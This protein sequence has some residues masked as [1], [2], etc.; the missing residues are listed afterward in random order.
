MAY[1]DIKRTI[2]SMLKN[3][4]NKSLP[5]DVIYNL[6]L[7]QGL[8]KSSVSNAKSQLIADGVIEETRDEEGNKIITLINEYK[9][10]FDN[11][12]SLMDEDTLLFEMVR[13][14]LTNY[15]KSKHLDEI[16]ITLML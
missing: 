3:S 11:E 12:S 4:L 13:D 8:P 10:Y 7:A 9:L 1:E 6:L 15:L 16:I 2:V 5:W 14:H